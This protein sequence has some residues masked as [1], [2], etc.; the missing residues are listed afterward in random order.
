VT[1]FSP[2]LERRAARIRLLLFDVDGVLTD[3][4]I[5]LHADGTE[6]K[7]YF[8]RD[9]TA[10]VLARQA[11]LLTGFLSARTSHSTAVR[12]AQLRVPI[13]RQGI[14]DKASA[15]QEILEEHGLEDADV[16]YM[17]DDLLD[18]PV[19]ARVG[20]ACAPANAVEE[21]LAR[22]HWTSRYDGGAGCVREIVELV[23]R[24]QDRWDS[25]LQTYLPIQPEER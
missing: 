1:S 20:L 7:Q 12:A 2:E 8:I 15:Y 9:G 11:E 10:L 24:A 19:L 4:R 3:G 22:V 5:V 18:L 21:V 17:G 25:V 6:S 14:H 23:L 16:A 13:V